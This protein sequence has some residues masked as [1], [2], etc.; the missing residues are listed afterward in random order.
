MTKSMMHHGIKDGGLYKNTEHHPFTSIAVSLD[1]RTVFAGSKSGMIIS[2]DV[3]TKQQL[4]REFNHGSAVN[5]IVVTETHVYSGADDGSIK[6]FKL[7]A[8]RRLGETAPYVSLDDPI[9]DTSGFS[10][11][12]AINAMVKR[13]AE[14][15]SSLIERVGAAVGLAT[16]SPQQY[17][18]LSGSQDGIVREWD[19]LLG[20]KTDPKEKLNV[21]FKLNVRAFVIPDVP[22][23]VDN[24]IKPWSY[25]GHAYMAEPV[26]CIQQGDVSDDCHKLQMDEDKRVEAEVQIKRRAAHQ[27]EIDAQ[28]AKDFPD[29]NTPFAD[30]EDVQQEA[31][32]QL[33][34]PYGAPRDGETTPQ[35][36]EDPDSFVEQRSVSGSR[37]CS[38]RS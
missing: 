27:D 22:V 30:P 38:T 35:P 31:K 20:E 15:A 9:R 12:S 7:A 4:T 11:A 24:I 14:S 32:R 29:L 13:N 16:P 33:D 6:R 37:G 5:S 23:V 19:V 34:D 26:G 28:I 36:I 1:D 2:F 18:L 8:N 21:T 17:S 10:E 25:N 3:E